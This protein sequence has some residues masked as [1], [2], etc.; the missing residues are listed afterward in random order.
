MTLKIAIACD[1]GGYALKKVLVETFKDLD[2]DWLDLGAN[3]EESVDYPDFGYKLSEAIARGDAQYGVA[4]CGSGVGISI[5][6]NRNPAVRCVLC[7]EETTARLSRQHNNANVIA[8]GARLIGP[9]MAKACLK[10]FLSTEFEG[11]R[12]QRRVDKLTPC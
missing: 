9:D 7:S 6:V 5:A 12:H 1:H 10:T 2:I 8:F 3:S 4:I 11:G